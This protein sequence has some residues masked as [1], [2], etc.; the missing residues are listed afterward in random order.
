MICQY[1]IHW[2][3]MELRILFK[4]IDIQMI[5]RQILPLSLDIQKPK[6]IQLQRGGEVIGALPL[7][8]TSSSAPGPPR[9]HNPRPSL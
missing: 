2:L 4:I 7:A 6:S 8:L 1:K 5:Q 3:Y 9:G